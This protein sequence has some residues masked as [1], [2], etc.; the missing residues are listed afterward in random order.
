MEGGEEINGRK[1]TIGAP[2]LFQESAGLVNGMKHFR[3]N[4]H[5][6]DVASDLSSKS[7][8]G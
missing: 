1:A 7:L 5:H 6:C 3:I 8:A 4:L 2:E